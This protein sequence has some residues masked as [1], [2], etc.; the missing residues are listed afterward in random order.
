MQTDVQYPYPYLIPDDAPGTILRSQATP[1]TYDVESLLTAANS[2]YNT[3]YRR[4]ARYALDMPIP[5]QTPEDLAL[6]QASI[7][8]RTKYL[9]ECAKDA[10]RKRNK[11]HTEAIK[12]GRKVRS[13]RKRK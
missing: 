9:S 11:R 10:T 3:E 7:A 6:R 8:M 13:Y 4:R 5:E 12:A 2:K 1:D